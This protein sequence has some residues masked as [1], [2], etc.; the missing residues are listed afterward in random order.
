MQEHP[1][2]YTDADGALL[3]VKLRIDE[4]GRGKRYEWRTPDGRTSRGKVTVSDLPLYRLVNLHDAAASE[5]VLWVEGEK[6]ADALHTA[7]FVAVTAAGGASQRDFGEALAPLAGRTVIVWPDN[8]RPGIA[9]GRW[10][11]EALARVGATVRW[12]DPPAAV[13]DKGDAADFLALGHGAAEVQAVI[14]GATEPPAGEDADTGADANLSDLPAVP[15]FPVN[16]LPEPARAYA[17]EAAAAIGCPV[18]YVAVPLLACTGAIVGN[19]VALAIKADYRQFPVLW[20]AMVGEPGT[21]KTPALREA[22]AGVHAIQDDL[23]RAYLDAL[24]RHKEDLAAWEKANTKERGKPPAEPRMADI[25][26]TD[27]TVEAIAGMIDPLPSDDLPEP[28]S[29]IVLEADELTGWVLGMNQYKGGKGSDRQRWLS[30]WSSS[31]LKVN[32]VRRTVYVTNPVIAVT[33]GLQPAVL[34]GLRNEAGRRDGFEERVLFTWPDPLRAEWSED[35]VDPAVRD[36]FI[37]LSRAL[38]RE[39]KTDRPVRLSPEAKQLWVTWFNENKRLV[40]QE[41]GILAGWYTK[42]DQQCARLSLILHALAHPDSFEQVAV[43][44][45]TMRAAIDLAEYF[46][47]HAHRALSRLGVANHG[48]AAGLAVRTLTRLIDAGADGLTTRELMKALGG[49][50][51]TEALRDALAELQDRGQVVVRAVPPGE[52]GGRPGERWI[53]VFA[54]GEQ[55][56]KPSKPAGVTD[57]GATDRGLHVCTYARTEA[58]EEAPVASGTIH[59]RVTL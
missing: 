41:T 39:A 12:I 50:V 54:G 31:A 56:C 3:F 47:A 10:V 57:E 38:R 37:A 24:A 59:G 19:A 13:G 48:R 14:E 23:K 58:N 9:Y 44:E 26:T 6:C 36:A 22:A 17:V 52:Q 8:D 34:E 25:F 29:G 1:Y 18:D 7:G 49:H 46:R 30:S 35:T 2:H 53:A 20:C 28:A 21:A 4:P 15:P 11:A 51:P 42:L 33:G 5:P 16:T 40:E 27:A 55:T 45:A 32:R 43:G